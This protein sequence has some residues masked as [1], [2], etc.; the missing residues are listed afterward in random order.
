MLVK[1]QQWTLAVSYSVLVCE[2]LVRLKTSTC[3]PERLELDHRNVC[4][5]SHFLI[6]PVIKKSQN[7]I[8]LYKSQD[9][10]VFVDTCRH[11]FTMGNVAMGNQIVYE[12]RNIKMRENVFFKPNILS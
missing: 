4:S 5:Y 7:I 11:C 10:K 6:S 12:A 9:E 2:M 3:H 8:T 1:C